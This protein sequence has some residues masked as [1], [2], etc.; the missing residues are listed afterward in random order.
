MARFEVIIRRL[1]RLGDSIAIGVNAMINRVYGGIRHER[2]RHDMPVVLNSGVSLSE[3]VEIWIE[4]VR[5]SNRET[6]L[7]RELAMRE[8]GF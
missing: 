1:E 3:A 7:A 2:V 6:K 8:R 4:S 5:K